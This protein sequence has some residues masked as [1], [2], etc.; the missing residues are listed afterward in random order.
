MWKRSNKVNKLY[1]INLRST[2]NFCI[3]KYAF[4]LYTNGTST[5]WNTNT[6]VMMNMRKTSR[7]NSINFSLLW[8]IKKILSHTQ[9]NLMSDIAQMNVLNCEHHFHSNEHT[10]QNWHIQHNG[11]ESLQFQPFCIRHKLYL[12]DERQSVHYQLLLDRIDLGIRLDS[13]CWNEKLIKKS[14]IF[15]SC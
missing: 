10:S 12:D 1:S 7:I 3:H 8:I 15:W 5:R 13:L 4:K 2:D 14:V 9:Q 11:R 6:R